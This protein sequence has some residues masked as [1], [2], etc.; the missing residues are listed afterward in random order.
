MLNYADCCALEVCCDTCSRK[1]TLRSQWWK[2][3]SSCVSNIA[4][5]LHCVVMV[6]GKNDC[7]CCLIAQCKAQ[8]RFCETWTQKSI[9]IVTFFLNRVGRCFSSDVVYQITTFL[10][11]VE[12]F[13]LCNAVLMPLFRGLHVSNWT[14]LQPPFLEP[15]AQYFK[16]ANPLFADQLGQLTRMD[17]RYVA[18][19]FE[20]K[21]FR[22][23]FPLLISLPA[24][25]LKISKTL[26]PLEFLEHM[27][28]IYETRY[29]K[30]THDPSLRKTLF[31]TYHKCLVLFHLVQ[32][33]QEARL[34]ENKTAFIAT[35]RLL[36]RTRLCGAQE[37]FV[38]LEHK[39][40]QE[41]A[42][43]GLKREKRGD[44]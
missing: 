44:E 23:T 38:S 14:P 4:T 16:I 10:S 15:F 13:R 18:S 36:L 34:Q 43:K 40:Q 39:Q 37:M 9:S 35:R 11:P 1:E 31:C 21:N 20:L 30:T 5:N 24:N 28:T 17:L 41:D 6:H 2:S 7:V 32:D 27:C 3:C 33:A 42:A 8:V 26:L 12:G 19:L 25:L 29:K 22:R